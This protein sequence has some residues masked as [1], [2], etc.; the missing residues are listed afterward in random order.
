MPAHTRPCVCI[1]NLPPPAEVLERMLE[2]LPAL[3]APTVSALHGGA[4]FAVQIAAEAIVVPTLIPHIKEHGGTDIVITSI[5]MLVA[6][7]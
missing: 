6:E 5:K 1:S 7:I 3:R 4:G 2:F